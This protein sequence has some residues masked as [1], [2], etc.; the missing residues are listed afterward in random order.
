MSGLVT[1]YDDIEAE[2]DP[3]GGDGYAGY[4]NGHWP[5]Y[6]AT[7]QRFPGKPVKSISVGG[8]D[9]VALAADIADFEDGD[10]TGP[11]VAQWALLKIQGGYGRPTIYCSL[12]L[13]DEAAVALQA[14]G[15]AFG[16]DVDW[17][18]ASYDG[19]AALSTNP[20]AV[21][22][23]YQS[24][25]NWDI[26][27]CDPNWLT[28]TPPAPINPSVVVGPS[29]EIDVNVTPYTYTEPCDSNGDGWIGVPYTWASVLSIV[30]QGPF[31]PVDGYGGEFKTPAFSGQERAQDGYI[32]VISWTGGPPNGQVVFRAEVAG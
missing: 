28:P 16:R 20:G 27:C 21:A 19:V 22:K 9:P 8:Y 4:V 13:Y 31:P 11:E 25:P 5:D 2:N 32:A 23:Q 14:V 10:Y 1:M 18:E 29:Q 6:P 3:P 26:S 17:W 24:T 15:L 12:S 7:V 30:P